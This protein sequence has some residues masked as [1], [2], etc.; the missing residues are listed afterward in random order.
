MSRWGRVE[1][2]G[3]EVV[4]HAET[5]LTEHPS[6]PRFVW[7][8][9]YDPHDPYEPPAPYSRTYEKTPYDG[10]IAYADSVL[11]RFV[12][13]LKQHGWY[14]NSL[15][16]VA[17]DHGE[18]LGEHGEDT[19]GIF[20]YDSTTHVPLLMKRP[21]GMQAGT[22]V[23]AQVRTTDILPTVLDLLNLS[24]PGLDGESLQPLFGNHTSPERPAFGETDYPVRFGW[25]PLRSLRADGHKY[26]EAPR[27]ELYDLTADPGER[28]NIYEPWN[29]LVKKMRAELAEQRAKTPAATSAG[30][31]GAGTMDELRALGYL[32]PADAGSSTTAPEPSLLPD[33]KDK[34]EQ[35]N[36]LHRAMMASEDNRSEDARRAL[37][38]V[39]QLDPKSMVALRQLGELELRAG[40]F[41]E[42]A[43]HLGEV[44]KARPDDAAAALRL[45]QAL[46]KLGKPEEARAAL[47][48]SLKLLPQQ[49]E[50]RLLLGN[51]YLRLQQYAAAE[52]QM[53]AAL[54]LQPDSLDAQMAIARAKI[55]EGRNEDA[56]SRL[57]SL[58][59]RYPKN[60][61]IFL[62]LSEAYAASGMPAKAQRARAQAEKL[63]ARTK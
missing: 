44:C 29:E 46:E 3:E 62:L 23:A 27:P 47:K 7:V 20:L 52:D 19:H 24:S 2:R 35:Q 8:H 55:A 9:L 56:I 11:G 12:A 15:L 58:T 37:E 4:K 25:A 63:K 32:G 53:E 1:R 49:Y 21:G 34:I 31:V 41:N 13:Y 17:G 14:E 22:I 18:G 59:A 10:E 61:E 48:N 51:V 60:P 26:I 30:A 45:G 28:D 38:R 36:L 5:W 42:A 43:E 39:L 33:P 16:V 54:L 50:A 57:N 6:G 40:D